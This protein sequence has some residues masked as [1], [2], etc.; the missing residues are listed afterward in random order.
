MWKYF[1]LSQNPQI[2]VCY[3]EDFLFWPNAEKRAQDPLNVP[4]HRNW[5]LEHSITIT[6]LSKT[7]KTSKQKKANKQR[8]HSLTLK[9]L[10]Q[11]SSLGIPAQS[12]GSLAHLKQ[13]SGNGLLF[14]VFFAFSNCYSCWFHSLY[15]SWTLLRFHTSSARNPIISGLHF[16]VLRVTILSVSFH[17]ILKLI[18]HFA[19]FFIIVRETSACVTF[20]WPS[21]VQS[22]CVQDFPLLAVAIFNFQ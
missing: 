14:P 17:E 16:W 7:K 21:S 5:V 12:I 10:Y 13:A 19:N 20:S 1:V 3:S 11:F 9:L 4:R 2:W 6:V 18:I 8:N 15:I 22:C